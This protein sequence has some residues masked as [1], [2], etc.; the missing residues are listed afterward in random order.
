MAVLT[1]ILQSTAL[2]VGMYFNDTISGKH[3]LV[4]F[5]RFNQQIMFLGPH[6]LIKMTL[7]NIIFAVA[8]V[9]LLFGSFQKKSKY[10]IVWIFHDTYTYI[11]YFTENI[12]TIFNFFSNENSE[13]SIESSEES[14]E[15]SEESDKSSED[16]DKSS[17]DYQFIFSSKYKIL[18][19]YRNQE[20]YLNIF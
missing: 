18:M 16:S 20:T 3:F 4:I 14:N 1:I 15:S 17:T 7:T 9:S 12:W 13:D 2:L 8:S 11:R 5:L 19:Q 10:L 6:S